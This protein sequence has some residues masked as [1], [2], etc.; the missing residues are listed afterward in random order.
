MGIN[1]PA[2]VWLAPGD[3]G[4]AAALAALAALT[5]ASVRRRTFRR[6]SL[7]ASLSTV[8]TFTPVTSPADPVC[9]EQS[10]TDSPLLDGTYRNRAVH[11]AFGADS[12]LR[13]TLALA[14]HAASALEIGAGAPPDA[15]PFR[16]LSCARLERLPAP[17]NLAIRGKRLWL[18]V[19]G[20]ARD[21][22]LMRRRLELACDL[23]DEWDQ[24]VGN[25]K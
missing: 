3:A 22:L 19:Q 8:G 4:A 14:T 18:T 16:A 6:R 10:P 23:A 17:W 11:M 9:R 25:K 2:D 24:G 13:I 15:A 21:P 7:A 20:D 1:L 12:T 5:V